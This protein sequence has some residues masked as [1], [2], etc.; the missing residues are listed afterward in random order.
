MTTKTKLSALALA[1]ATFTTTTLLASGGASAK[2][3]QTFQGHGPVV[4]GT[5]PTTIPAR[6][7]TIVGGPRA[8]RSPPPPPPRPPPS[9]PSSPPGNGSGGGTVSCHPFTG[10]TITPP[11]GGDHDRD[12][13]H[14]RDRDR[15]HGY[16]RD[17]GWGY[18]PEIVVEGVP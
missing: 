8:A 4:T 3:Q 9:P 2:L 13:N 17:H 6:Q 7:G 11:P 16:E 12:R 5:A 15:D 1:A 10:C 18:Q 14:D